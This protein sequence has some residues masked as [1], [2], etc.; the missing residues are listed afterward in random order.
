MQYLWDAD[1]VLIRLGDYPL[2][3]LELAGTLTGLASVYY[4][5]RANILT[6]PTG[7]INQCFFFLLF[8]Q[9]QLYSD[10][11]LQLVFFGVS[12]WGWRN[13]RSGKHEKVA[14]GR[15]GWQARGWH[16]LLIV[17]G[18]AGLGTAMGQV[19]RWLP[20]I[21]TLPAAFPYGDAFTTVA[22]ILAILLQARKKLESWWLW[23]ALDVVAI[24][25]YWAKD[26]RFI[27]GEYVVFLLMSVWGLWQWQKKIHYQASPGIN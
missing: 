23:I 19:H 22:S 18:T 6:W 12:V 16:L 7:L 5:S 11:L 13:W 4:A 21:F 26:I 20:A 25:I 17:L 2:S 10:M 1:Q 9:V 14:V 8:Y 15:L 27:A 3:F 24:G